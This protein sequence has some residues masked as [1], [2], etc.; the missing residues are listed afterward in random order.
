MTG[1]RCNCLH[2]ITH[3]TYSYLFGSHEKMDALDVLTNKVWAR[4]SGISHPSGS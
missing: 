2:V 4:T 3:A 1:I